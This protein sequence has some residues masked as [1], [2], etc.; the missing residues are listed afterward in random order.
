M[1]LVGLALID[2]LAGAGGLDQCVDMNV[3][4]VKDPRALFDG[5]ARWT[6]PSI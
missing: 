4:V 6:R 3:D 5:V 1:S 2:A